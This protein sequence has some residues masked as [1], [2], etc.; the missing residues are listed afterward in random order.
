MGMRLGLAALSA[1]A[2]ATLFSLSMAPAFAVDL[3]GMTLSTEV[4]EER[5]LA[6]S[7]METLGRAIEI[8]FGNKGNR[9]V[10]FR[11]AAHTNLT[12][13]R[14]LIEAGETRGSKRR[15]DQNFN[16]IVNIQQTASSLQLN[17]ES[18]GKDTGYANERWIIDI[19]VSGNSCAVTGYRYL[20]DARSNFSRLSWS[21]GKCS[22]T[23]GPPSGLADD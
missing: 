5:M 4:R 22:L 10:L 13:N 2:M 3:A 21:G 15:K 12:E 11:P 19:G 9:F 23:S 17:I 1:A 16:L 20:P 14:V 6:N 7:K 18:R 8:Y